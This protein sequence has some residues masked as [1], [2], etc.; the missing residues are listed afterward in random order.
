MTRFIPLTCCAFLLLL[1]LPVAAGPQTEGVYNVRFTVREERIHVTYD[2]VGEGTYAVALRL[3]GSSIRPRTV[4]GDVGDRIQ[5]G[6]N[7]KVVWDA[8][9]DVIALE[10]DD[11]VFEV[12]AVRTRRSGKWLLIAGTGAAG[13]AGISLLKA[14]TSDKGTIAI[15]VRD[16]D[17]R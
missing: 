16:P 12:T 11:L 15:D 3:V 7:K 14:E 9:K 8:L 17:V 6:Q 13:V 2:L 10:E 1:H 5:S 4:S